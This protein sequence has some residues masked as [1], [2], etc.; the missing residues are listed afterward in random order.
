MTILYLVPFQGGNVQVP[1]GSLTPQKS[2]LR[3][4]ASLTP[5]AISTAARHKMEQIAFVD[6]INK[7]ENRAKSY[8]D[9]SSELMKLNRSLRLAAEKS[10]KVRP[11]NPTIFR[12][13]LRNPA[14]VRSGRA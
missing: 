10:E 9:R 1:A 14:L 5:G 3:K 6:Q 12:G 11:E 7:M 8:E 4:E 2:G 13:S